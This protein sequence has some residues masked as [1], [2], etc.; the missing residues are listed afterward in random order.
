METTQAQAQALVKPQERLLKARIPKTYWSKSH[1]E[2]YH[3]CQQYEDYFQ[4]FVAIEIN[5]IPFAISFFRGTI[6]V[7]WI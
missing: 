3:F 1:I 2:Y 5:Y 7:R 6:S 4:I